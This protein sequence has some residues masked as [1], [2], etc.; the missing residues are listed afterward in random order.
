LSLSST[1]SYPGGCRSLGFPVVGGDG[2]RGWGSR[3][4]RLPWSTSSHLDVN[5]LV[6]EPDVED[7]ADRG[8]LLR[9]R[10]SD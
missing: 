1:S 8:L 10:E 6:V 5:E 4:D 9:A 2:G 3:W 7:F